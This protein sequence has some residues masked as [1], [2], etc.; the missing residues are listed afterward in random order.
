[1]SMRGLCAARAQFVASHRSCPRI[2][3]LE[4]IRGQQRASQAL[5]R[6]A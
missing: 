6:R 4:H 3:I 1:M 5:R 2:G